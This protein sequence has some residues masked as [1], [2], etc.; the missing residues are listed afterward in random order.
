MT[1]NEF[2]TTKNL[3]RHDGAYR[4]TRQVDLSKNTFKI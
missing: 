3:T 2:V 4:G 1:S